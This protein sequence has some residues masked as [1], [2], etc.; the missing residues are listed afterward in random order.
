MRQNV[1]CRVA[2]KLSASY[3]KRIIRTDADVEKNAN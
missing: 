1:V 3:I 2:G